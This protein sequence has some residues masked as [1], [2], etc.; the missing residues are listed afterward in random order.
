MPARPGGGPPGGAEAEEQQA[1]QDEM[2]RQLLSQILDND[3]RER[4]AYVPPAVCSDPPVSRI[5][6]VKPQKSRA[7]T[8]IL[9][10]MARSGQVRQ[11][12]SEAQLIS[13]LDQVEQASGGES[14]AKI[15]VR[16]RRGYRPLTGRSTGKRLWTATTSWICSPDTVRSSSGAAATGKKNL[17]FYSASASGASSATLAPTWREK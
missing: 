11:R 2:K 7:V 10:Q 13:L 3:A 5:A 15:T 9:I 12:V 17:G 16:I 6:L 4:C 8:D 1:Q 14:A